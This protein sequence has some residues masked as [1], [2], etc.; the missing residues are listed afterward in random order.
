MASQSSRSDG[1]EHLL[2]TTGNS[3]DKVSVSSVE[4]GQS[5]D[6]SLT[7]LSDMKQV[8]AVRGD[9]DAVCLDQGQLSSACS[10]EVDKT[11]SSASEPVC[12]DIDSSDMHSDSEELVSLC[13]ED[14]VQ[15][16]QSDADRQQLS[17]TT[18]QSAV[19]QQLDADAHSSQPDHS[20]FSHSVISSSLKNISRNDDQGLVY[21]IYSKHYSK[22]VNTQ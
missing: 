3:D 12:V 11:A 14:V 18:E 20:G 19:V 1:T 17:D 13:N 5:G 9:K 10:E 8:D 4:G 21:I 22:Y 15:S 6:R 16:C 2:S 7:D